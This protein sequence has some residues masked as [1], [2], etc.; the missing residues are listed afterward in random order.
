MPTFTC[1]A[2]C[3]DCGTLSSPQERTRL[4]SDHIISA[5]D[6]AKD[7][8]FYNVVF[9]GGEA[10]LRWKDLLRGISHARDLGFPVRLVTNAHWARDLDT[11]RKKLGLLIDAG[12]SEINYSTGDEHVKFVPIDR[13]AHAIVAACERAFR[14]H[15]MVELKS[16]NSVTRDAVLK[17]PLVAALD[18]EQLEFLSVEFSPWMPM[19]HSSTHRYPAGAAVDRRNIGRR[20]GCDS[21]LQ[22]YTVQADGRIG[23]CCG[24]G[25][26]TIPE[27]SVS[28]VDQPNF[29][30][31]AITESE[32][33]LL[34]LWIHY[35]GPER[36]VA[37]AA[38]HNP[39]ITWEGRY[40]H[41]C[42]FCHRL[43]HDD[44][45]RQVILDHWEEAI[46]EVLRSAWLDEIHV[47]QAV[48][49]ALHTPMPN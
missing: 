8:G 20:P 25:M 2:A 14:V 35:E 43:Y 42:Q 47:P 34:K 29:L 19:S 9:T 49:D 40:A 6:E 31:R 7:L 30:R 44:A 23:A 21:I 37:W 39:E 38:R 26:R 22:T 3:S 1:P 15:V 24:L 45:V 32:E 12:L 4:E 48:A 13:V 27:L 5:I 46:A 33:D 17:H 18:P 28:N 10:T 16:D 11:A 36:I 41:H